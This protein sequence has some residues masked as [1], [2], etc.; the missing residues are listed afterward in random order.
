MNAAFLFMSIV[1][2]MVCVWGCAA[3]GLWGRERERR[4]VSHWAVQNNSYSRKMSMQAE[5]ESEMSILHLNSNHFL[6]AFYVSVP[7]D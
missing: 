5:S 3:M 2:A 6:V 7:G 1:R 4:G